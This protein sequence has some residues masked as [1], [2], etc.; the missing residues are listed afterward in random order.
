MGKNE[1]RAYERRWLI[2]A[3]LCFSLLIIVLDNSILNV[4]IPTIVRELHATN[5]QLQW[6]VD[7]YTLVFAG[8]LLTAGA[9]GDRFG[10]RGALQ[11][12]FAIFGLGSI[13][14]ASA[15]SANQLI[16]TRALMG[17]GGALIMPA[18]LSIITNVFPAGERGRAIGVWA[19]VAGL[20]AALGPLTGGFL[21]EH[22][23]WG[24]VFLV[25]IPIVI[26]GLIAG[27]LII[28]T[29][30]DPSAPRLDPIGAVLSIVGLTALL[31]AII[32]APSDGWGATNI[33]IGFIVGIVLL[34][35]FVL[36]E[37]HTDHPMLDVRFFENPRFTAASGSITLTFFAMFG[38]I[39]LLTQYQQFVLGYS[40]L[41][42]G[43]RML[44]FAAAMMIT[45]PTSARLA[46]RVGTKVLV[47]TGMVIIT[48]VLLSMTTL[49]VD[50]PYLTLGIRLFLFGLGM[51]LVMAPATDSVMGSLP[52]AKAGVGSAV[53]D[54][55]R[56]VGGAMGV[57][58]VGSVLASTYGNKIG[59]FFAGT[60][61]PAEAVTAARGVHRGRLRRRRR[62]ART[63]VEHVDQH[64][65]PGLRRSHALGCRRRRHR[66]GNR[67]LRGVVLPP[68][69]RP[70]GRRD[71]TGPR[72][73][74]RMEW[75]HGRSRGG[76]HVGAAPGIRHGARQAR[77]MTTTESGADTSRIGRPRSS[78]ADQAILDATVKLFADRGYD[79]L[80]IEAVA[81]QAGVA[82][83]TIYRRYTD[84]AEL[85][86][87]AVECSTDCA[88]AAPD[89]G[90][91]ADDLYL[92]AQHLRR[93]LTSTD[94]GKTLPATIAAMERHP[95][96]AEAHQAF[97]SRRR[98]AALTAVE[99]GIARGEIAK[100]TDPE[101]FVDMVAGPIFYRTFVRRTSVDDR[102]LRSLVDAAVAW[103]RGRRPTNPS[104]V[105]WSARQ[106][107]GSLGTCRADA[108]ATCWWSSWRFSP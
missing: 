7:S 103:H 88:S 5:S 65:E 36:W 58:I 75:R 64:G 17:V 21:V 84:K 63:T 74:G 13:L 87:A 42:T 62:I 9:L 93:V 102:T 27:V 37:L 35:S 96:L 76:R 61:A 24:S 33:M 41:Q 6:I 66:H 79:G 4:A 52:L 85:L 59:D 107:L 19:G 90:S 1:D 23:Y 99:R 86:L 43:V 14:S 8:L 94:A 46:E 45:A 92:I 20:G 29:S 67:R 72:V 98:H 39:F 28:P 30:K 18:T 82:K 26:F 49:Q 16:A 57:T 55:T 101:L 60:P 77:P 10:R 95:A 69:P 15:G 47:T 89:T 31:Y 104:R 100:D 48:L 97:L 32:E 11:T 105:R 80:T 22:F 25:N 56:Q 53:N 2:L 54:T 71:R 83:S 68:G 91:L 12:G 50:T 3:V 34:G 38:A 73:R 51:G 40:P 106:P 108:P 78:T 81:E 44:P 70:Q